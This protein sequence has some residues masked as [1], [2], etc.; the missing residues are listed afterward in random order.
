MLIDTKKSPYAKVY[1]L[2]QNSVKWQP[3]FWLDR[4]NTCVDETIPHILSVFADKESFFHQVENFKIAAGLSDGEFRGTPY[5]DGDFYKLMEGLTY[6]YAHRND[7]E[8][9]ATLDEYITLIAAAQQPDGYISTKQIIGEKL[10]NGTFRHGDVND[11]EEYN[12]GHLFTSACVH[13]RVTGKENFLNIARHCAEYLEG[14]YRGILEEGKAH[15]AVCPSHYMGLFEMY[16]TTGEEKYLAMGKTAIAIRDMVENGSDDN[17]DRIPLKEHRKIVGHAVRS[18]YLYAGAADMYLE[19]G[20]ESL[21]AV[22]DSCWDNLMNSK[23]YINGGCGALYTGTSPF[24]ML[25][26]AQYVHQAFGYEYQLPNITAYNETCGT[27]GHIF[28]A[29]RMFAREPKAEYMD[30]IEGSYY[31]LV[32]AAVSLDGRKYFYENML[33]RTKDL[34]YP[35][36]WPVERSGYFS[37]FCCPTNVSRSIPEAVDYS[38]RVSADAVWC[39]MYGANEASI[40]LENG[41]AFNLT[42]ET[43]YPWSGNIR[44]KISDLTSP[45]TLKVRVPGW[46][47]KGSITYGDM[48]R[49]LSEVNGKTYVGVPITKAGDVDIFFDMPVRMMEAHPKVEEDTSQVCITRGPLVYCAESHDIC[50]DMDGIMVLSD[51]TFE[52]SSYEIG[53]FPMVALTCDAARVVRAADYNPDALYQP[54]K[55]KGLEGTKLRLIPYFAWDNRG[56]GE[57]RTWFP[58]HYNFGTRF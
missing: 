20:D 24:G 38:Y 15:T 45:F 31:N 57:M 46:V 37:C 1:S 28:W 54:I 23:I 11:F 9:D 18:T 48:T 21:P 14:M 55:V 26:D 10:S 12:F 34:D 8:I 22:L 56:F 2:P 5:G 17:Q 35:V 40:S 36:M 16:R 58:V 43:N 52:E 47:D 33:R 49:S 44:I 19:T 6:A 50:G 13:Y 25:L 29:N 3:G 51:A 42:Q 53:G 32:L 27:L 41:A 7:P 39:G 4:F 30:L